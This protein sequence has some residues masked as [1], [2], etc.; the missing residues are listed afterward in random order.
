MPL[1]VDAALGLALA[2]FGLVVAVAGPPGEAPAGLDGPAVLAAVLTAT[3]VTLRGR[4]PAAGI[5]VLT[6]VAVVLLATG[7]EQPILIAALFFSFYT[8][9]GTATRRALGWTTGGVSAVLYVAS[10]LWGGG[11]WW[12]PQSIGVVAW[13]GMAAAIGDAIRSRRAY[14]AEVEHRADRA[15]ATREQE[16][17]RRVAEE[18]LRI[19]RELHDV[20]AHHIAVIKVQASGAKH[21]LHHRP[22][23]VGPALDH[24]SR[25]SDAVL[26]E[27]A[28]V[29]GLLRGTADATDP[30]GDATEPTRGLAR[31]AGLLDDL[32]AS[33][34]RVDHRQIGAARPLPAVVDL[35]AYRIV[36]EALTNAQKYGDRTAELTLAYDD[37]GV[38]LTVTNRIRGD[39]P[40]TGSSLGLIGMRER[41]LAAGGTVTA[42]PSTPNVFT[43]RAI[44]PTTTKVP[45]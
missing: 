9:A 41:A 23:Q 8:Y 33:G 12:S 38:T 36:Q 1:L 11:Q 5:V 43:V 37:D 20:M 14:I 2:T 30:D 28:A 39:A 32:A 44:L 17:Q 10:V 29:L 34:L 3:A 26:T 7:G 45:T 19:A 6:L 4:W 25:A 16:A 15:E 27:I 35:A 13:I 40:R 18:R 21:I 22:E 31:L 42:A 24:I